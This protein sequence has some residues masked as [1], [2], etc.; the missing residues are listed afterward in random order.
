M[1]KN[2]IESLSKDE[3]FNKSKENEIIDNISKEEFLKWMTD[4][5]FS[6]SFLKTIFDEKKIG[7]VEQSSFNQ[8]LRR[9][10][11]EMNIT[12][13]DSVL[14]LEDSLNKFKK[15]I[16]YLDNDTKEILKK[17]LAKKYRIKIESN[18]LYKIL[19]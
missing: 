5:G 2:K 10:K 7:S 6:K 12:I 13:L 9:T 18:N 15:I 14:Y 1:A 8:L 19:E 4:N 17:E 3:V 16:A 11:K